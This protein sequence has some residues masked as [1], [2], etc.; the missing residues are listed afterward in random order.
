MRHM[1]TAPKDLE[2]DEN[3]GINESIAT[4]S[5]SENWS[6]SLVGLICTICVGS[7]AQIAQSH[8]FD[9]RR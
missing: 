3:L 1:E 7:D 4:A 8:R 6:R 5:S 2:E 9:S